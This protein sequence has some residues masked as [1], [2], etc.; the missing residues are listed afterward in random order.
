MNV[1]ADFLVRVEEQYPE[2]I[3]NEELNSLLLTI[4]NQSQEINELNKEVKTL[5]NN[6]LNADD[7]IILVYC[8]S[9]PATIQVV[10]RVSVD[11]RITM[12][13]STVITLGAAEG[14]SISLRRRWAAS[15]PMWRRG[16]STVVSIG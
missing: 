12:S 4:R 9:R 3:D 13:A 15:R 16:A 8:D 7:S 5:R 1:L 10:G 2:S 14:L 11:A 6:I